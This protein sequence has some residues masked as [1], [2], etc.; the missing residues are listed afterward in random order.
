MRTRD[1]RVCDRPGVHEDIYGKNAATKIRGWRS[2]ECTGLKVQAVEML[3]QCYVGSRG[4]VRIVVMKY[5][6]LLQAASCEQA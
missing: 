5:P 2:S 3:S 6:M 4:K 1:G